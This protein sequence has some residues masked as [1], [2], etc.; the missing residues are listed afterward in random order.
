[1]AVAELR[2]YFE[3]LGLRGFAKNCPWDSQL[4]MLAAHLPCDFHTF[5]FEYKSKS[6]AAY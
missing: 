4:L 6:L 5:A 3:Q 2:A 1:M